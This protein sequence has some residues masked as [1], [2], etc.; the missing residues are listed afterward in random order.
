[1]VF[2]FLKM[3]INI[4]QYVSVGQHEEQR[5]DKMQDF[6]KCMLVLTKGY[7]TTNRPDLDSLGRDV[8]LRQSQT[9][10]VM[11][12]MSG[13]LD[14]AIGLLHE[15]L[16]ETLNHLPASEKPITL[17]FISEQSVSFVL[18]IGKNVIRGIDPAKGVFRRHAGIL[19]I[20]GPAKITIKGFEWDVTDWET[21]MG[22]DVSTSNHVLGDEVVIKVMGQSVLFTIE[23]SEPALS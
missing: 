8:P 18:P 20:Y 19:P 14:Q 12:T 7:K 2:K 21:M 10:A 1:M 4:A 17:Y 23:L 16:R 6:A 15:M 13:R 22:A 11:S 9:I 5:I 3:T